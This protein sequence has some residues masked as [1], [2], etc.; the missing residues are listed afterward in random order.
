MY[1]NGSVVLLKNANKKIMI[2]GHKQI[3]MDDQLLYDYVGCL[4]PEGFVSPSTNVFFNNHDIHQLLFK[5]HEE[6]KTHQIYNKSR[7]GSGL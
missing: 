7:L 1:P 5:G 4:H 3:R 6:Q 2:Y